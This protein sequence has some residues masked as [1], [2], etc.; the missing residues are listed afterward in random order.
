MVDEAGI[1]PPSC[2]TRG[3]LT[4]SHNSSHGLAALAPC[5]PGRQPPPQALGPSPRHEHQG[6]VARDGRDRRAGQVSGHVVTQDRLRRDLPSRTPRL[7]RGPGLGV[8]PD[9]QHHLLRHPSRPLSTCGVN[10]LGR[11]RYAVSTWLPPPVSPTSRTA[12]ADWT[13]AGAA[14]APVVELG[15][16]RPPRACGRPCQHAVSTC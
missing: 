13:W 3:R 15:R 2:A 7:E 9:A 16:P 1:E 12:P 6:A 11:R 5:R 10:M 8:E 4:A 14:A